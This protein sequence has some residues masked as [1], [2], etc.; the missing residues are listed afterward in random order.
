MPNFKKIVR[1]VSWESALQ[2]HTHRHTHRQT[3]KSDFIGPF[4]V[5]WRPNKCLYW[6]NYKVTTEKNTEKHIVKNGKKI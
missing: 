3:D 1:A 6:S 2:T 4:P 5:N